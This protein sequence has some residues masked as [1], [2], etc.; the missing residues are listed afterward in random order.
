MFSNPFFHLKIGRFKATIHRVAHPSV[1]KQGLQ[2]QQI[3]QISASNLLASVGNSC[4][5]CSDHWHIAA[6]TARY[7][8]R[9]EDQL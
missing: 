9:L 1:L 4:N 7:A 5:D 2:I 3:L 6:V 8:N